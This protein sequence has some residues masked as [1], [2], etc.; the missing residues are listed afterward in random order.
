MK[1][2]HILI[3]KAVNINSNIVRFFA[4]NYREMAT[5]K[6]DHVFHYFQDKSEFSPEE[7]KFFE[8]LPVGTGQLIFEPRNKSNI[9]KMLLA[10]SKRDLIFIHSGRMSD[11]F[12]IMRLTPWLWKRT[13]LIGFGCEPSLWRKIAGASGWKNKVLWHSLKSVVPSLK[14]VCTLTPREYG[15]IQALFNRV[16]NYQRAFIS[17]S[18]RVE[19][20]SNIPRVRVNSV[21]VRVLLNQSA[22]PDGRHR[23]AL[24]WLE[25]F[26]D[27]DIQ[28]ICPVSFGGEAQA[29]AIIRKG[30]DLLGEKFSF[31]KEKISRDVYSQ[32][33]LKDMDILI[34]NH[35][36][37]SGL[38]HLHMFLS[39]G[40][41]A[42]IRRESPVYNFLG[43]I[44][45]EVRATNDIPTM[46]FKEFVRPLQTD[47][48]ER[49]I[50]NFNRHL[51]TEASLESCRQLIDN[52]GRDRE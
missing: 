32:M 12:L 10:I 33:V 31:I 37:Q 29:E 43:Q 2:R 7:S 17:T 23:E 21:P 35:L 18:R 38:G 8:G 25:T 22:N 51:S 52:M 16:D 41:V 26:R 46:S 24:E 44:G 48:A 36:G 6:D 30:R 50:R 19:V 49:N 40:K 15:L 42:Y 28:V 34:L 45:I 11:L 13:A 5:E 47:R 27:D 9:L 20:T 4:T 39:T 1:I 3:G 14:A